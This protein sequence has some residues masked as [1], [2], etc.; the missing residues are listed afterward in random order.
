MLTPDA[1]PVSAAPAISPGGVLSA[2][3]FGAFGSVAP[4]SWIEIYGTRLAASTRKWTAADFVGSQAPTSLNGTKVKI[5]GVDAFLSYVSSTQVN[6]LIPF[7]VS[8]GAQELTVTTAAG[9]SAPYTIT[10]NTTQPGL[11]APALFKIGGRQYAG[12]LSADG[13]EFVFPSGSVPGTASRRA[14]P[15]ETIVLYGV[16][17]GQVA[18]TADV[19]QVVQ[20]GNTL[21][22]PI[23]IFFGG[24]R[25]MVS[26][27]GLVPGTVGLYQFNVVVPGTIAGDTVPVTFSQGA[28]TG[29]QTLYTAVQN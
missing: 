16:G 14:R 23:E 7:H 9:T 28:T 2:S 17:F 8:A 10:V 6:A 4:G 19:G 22:T 21:A 25:A 13:A 1:P 20:Q 24:T 15:G 3:E 27:Q 26:Y 18:P 5:G 29:S 12:A 11:Y